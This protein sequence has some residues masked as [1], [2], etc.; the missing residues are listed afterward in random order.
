MSINR[1]S[2]ELKHTTEDIAQLMHASPTGSPV[3]TAPP[4][5]NVSEFAEQQRLCLKAVDE[6]ARKTLQNDDF[7]DVCLFLDGSLAR[8]EF[9]LGISDL[10]FLAV[11]MMPGQGE[12][13]R[14]SGNTTTPVS[15]RAGCDR[16]RGFERAL[17]RSVRRQ[18]KKKLG[19]MPDVGVGARPLLGGRAFFTRQSL[20]NE[21]GREHEANWAAWGRAVLLFEAAAWGKLSSVGALRRKADRIY[22][23]TED[24]CGRTFPAMGCSFLGLMSHSGL[25]AKMGV[26]KKTSDR[27][28]QAAESEVG[29]RARDS[30]ADGELIKAVFSRH[31]YSVVNRLVLH[32]LYWHSIIDTR[33]MAVRQIRAALRATPIFKMVSF[34][35]SRIA[36]AFS[37]RG[38]LWR[39]VTKQMQGANRPHPDVFEDR[40]LQVYAAFARDASGACGFPCVPLWQ[41]FLQILQLCIDIRSERKQLNEMT[42]GWLADVNKEL[43]VV[44]ASSRWLTRVLLPPA[45]ATASTSRYQTLMACIGAEIP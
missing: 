25:V 7:N 29:E 26:L 41:R 2:R 16:F 22:G 23:V 15:H 21:L 24:C 28:G 39:H 6:G 45:R 18:M 11:D 10:D 17:A 4:L 14:A 8:L 27:G 13:T 5:L 36:E 44:M 35:P 3:I 32:V 34:L 40:F 30:K 12:P 43:E 1:L 31:W 9:L 42:L 20:F 38:L 37:Q 19:E 33:R